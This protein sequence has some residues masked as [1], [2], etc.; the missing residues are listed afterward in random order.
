MTTPASIQQIGPD[1]TLEQDRKFLLYT[2]TKVT[3][4]S[5]DAFTAHQ[6]NLYNAQAPEIPIYMMCDTSAT[7]TRSLS[8]YFRKR[9]EEITMLAETRQ[10]LVFVAAILP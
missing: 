9:L 2:M 5:V 7:G 6:T 3:R 4:E 1:V 10:L 8:P